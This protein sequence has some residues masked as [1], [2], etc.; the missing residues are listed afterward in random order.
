MFVRAKKHG[1]RTYWYLV[2]NHREGKRTLQRVISY[3]G[4]EKPSPQVLQRIME[5]VID[6]REGLAALGEVE[7]TLSLKDYLAERGGRNAETS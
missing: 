7:G 5:D 1:D 3:L 6:A 4:T 2:E